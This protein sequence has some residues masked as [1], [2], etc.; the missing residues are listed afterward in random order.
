[1]CSHYG[2]A[3]PGPAE[4]ARF[5]A[6]LARVERPC[7]NRH[8]AVAGKAAGKLEAQCA[9]LPVVG[10]RQVRAAIDAIEAVPAGARNELGCPAAR[11]KALHVVLVAVEDERRPAGERVPERLHVGLIPMDDARAVARAVPEGEAAGPR[12]SD[13]RA[14]PLE[15]AGTGTVGDLGVEAQDL[16]AGGPE[17]VVGRDLPPADVPPVRV[18]TARV[19][20]PVVVAGCGRD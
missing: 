18:V 2:R 12:A 5:A 3:A 6:N 8:E 20:R 4:S 11:S 10:E 15:L 14:E 7:P 16:P 13:P 19:E 9:E 1:M 17:G